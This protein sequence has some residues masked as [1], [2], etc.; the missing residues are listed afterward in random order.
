MPRGTCTRRFDVCRQIS[1]MVQG[2]APSAYLL[3][4]PVGVHYNGLPVTFDWE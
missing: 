4:T 3:D 1:Q 2:D